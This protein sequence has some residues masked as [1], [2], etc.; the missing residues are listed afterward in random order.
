MYLFLSLEYNKLLKSKNYILPV[1]FTHHKQCLLHKRQ[2]LLK[3]NKRKERRERG[4]EERRGGWKMTDFSHLNRNAYF[5]NII[6]LCEKLY[7]CVKSN[8]RYMLQNCRYLN[9]RSFYKY[10][11]SYSFSVS[12]RYFCSLNTGNVLLLLVSSSQL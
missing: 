3:K 2:C 1:L 11:L 8:H 12:M 5:W 9:I 10:P 6:S 4:G 7:L